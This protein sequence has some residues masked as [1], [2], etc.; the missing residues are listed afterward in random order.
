MLISF[1]TSREVLRV[2]GVT[3]FGIYNLV[4]GLTTMFGFLNGSL[5]DA[6]Q[7]YITVEIGKKE[8]GNPNKIF[9]ICLMG[10]FL[11]GLLIFL[12]AEPIGL[13]FIHHK[14]VIPVDRIG[15]ATWVFQLS[16][17]SMFVLIIS[18]PY[19]ALIIA[20]ERMK[21]FAMI[22]IVDAVGKLVIVYFL[23]FAN[24]DRLILYG[25]L[26]LLLQMAIRYLYTHYCIRNFKESKLHFY[27]D[28]PLF[29][30][31]SGFASW[32]IIGNLSYLCVT[33]GINIIL[34]M[35]FMPAINAARGIAVQVQ[36]AVTTF[37]R[38]FQTA[39]NPQITKTYA[40]NELSNMHS[41]IFRSSRFSF[42]LV[43]ILLLPII[44]EIDTMLRIWL[45][46]VPEYTS[47]FARL[48]LLVSLVNCV[49]NPLSIAVKATGRIKEFELYAATL[50]LLVIP[51]AYYLLNTGCPPV[52]VFVLYLVFETAAFISNLLIT[53]HYV[54]FD[55]STYCRQVLKKLIIVS[56]TSACVPLL[57]FLNMPSTPIRFILVI[58]TS[59]IC[60]FAAIY[61]L[62]LT[63]RERFFI[64]NK[65]HSILNK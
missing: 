55:L 29:K 60:S 22:S 3:D 10:H 12:F 21:T 25:A 38:N 63:S 24:I 59:F 62:G 36:N 37:V 41:L 9:S 17:V 52:V 1:F 44:L 51:F 15:A 7:R 43:M 23:V 50:K 57:L 31:M 13:W 40:A 28:W 8:Q 33:Q 39:I 19:N 16:L 32:A 42:Y 58:I 48:L 2:L 26:I 61:F 11:L 30:E 54:C 27:W 4:G 46:E 6:T 5:S 20:H 35:F 49:G 53:R 65:I 14:L 34:G 45:T 64:K 56:L 18:V 47:T